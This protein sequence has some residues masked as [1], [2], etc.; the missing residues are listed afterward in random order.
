MFIA[1]ALLPMTLAAVAGHRAD[2]ALLAGITCAAVAFYGISMFELTAHRDNLDHH[3]KPHLLS[4]SWTPVPSWKAGR[5]GG[6]GR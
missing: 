3:E 2:L 5:R 4:D 6:D 1:V